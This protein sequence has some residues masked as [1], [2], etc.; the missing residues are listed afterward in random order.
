MPPPL[1]I[2]LVQIRWVER[3]S[4]L[5]RGLHLSA[6]HFP[7]PLRLVRLL[8]AFSL[9]VDCCVN[10]NSRFSR[11]NALAFQ[12][13]QLIKR[14]TNEMLKVGVYSKG[15]QPEKNNKKRLY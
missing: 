12:I 6:A 3:A 14:W 7:T 10:N 15:L 8:V 13:V 4:R 2:T 11:R 5:A 1:L 9:R